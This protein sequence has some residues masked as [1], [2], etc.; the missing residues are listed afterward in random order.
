[1]QLSV[2]ELLSVGI[3][4]SKTVGD[5]GTHGAGVAGIQGI[6][7]S[8]PNAAAVADATTGLAIDV[9]M[10]NGKILTMGI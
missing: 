6:G 5:P 3:L 4:A 8:T 10:A 2:H 1:M 7:V 9:H